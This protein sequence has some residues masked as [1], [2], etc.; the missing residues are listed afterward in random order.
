MF[1]QVT[2]LLFI[3]NSTPGS[4]C[5]Q[6]TGVVR[7]LSVYKHCVQL[8]ESGDLHVEVASEIIR[9]LM[10]EVGMELSRLVSPS[11]QSVMEMMV[12]FHF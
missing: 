5:F 1:A 11:L 12:P 9:L 4:P 6:Q 3:G 8:V 2:S 7:R 10:L